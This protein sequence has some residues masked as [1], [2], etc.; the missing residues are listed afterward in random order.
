[1]LLPKVIHSNAVAIYGDNDPITDYPIQ[2]FSVFVIPELGAVSD[3]KR[4]TCRN[5]PL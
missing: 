5:N 4:R 1:M 2:S 3:A